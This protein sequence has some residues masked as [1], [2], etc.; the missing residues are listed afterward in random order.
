MCEKQFYN[1][2]TSRTVENHMQS[3]AQLT[4]SEHRRLKW[5]EDHSRLSLEKEEKNN[6]ILMSWWALHHTCYQLTAAMEIWKFYFNL[7]KVNLTDRKSFGRLVL[8]GKI[9]W[10]IE[11]SFSNCF[12]PHVPV[13]SHVSSSFITGSLNNNK[14]NVLTD[15]RFHGRGLDACS[16]S[17]IASFR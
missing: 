8:F 6:L 12:I 7:K 17:A 3:S 1:L 4:V 9:L 15:F 14:K 13:S 2:C 16:D 10:I 11:E 5:W